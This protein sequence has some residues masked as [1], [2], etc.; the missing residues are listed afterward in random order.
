MTETQITRKNGA[1]IAFSVLVIITIGSAIL[2]SAF[3]NNFGSIDVQSIRF[4]DHNGVPIAAKL[5]RPT[6][7]SATNP[8]PGI[9]ALH[10]FNN[11]KDVMR[12]AAIE[13]AKAGFVVL[14]ID[15]EGD[16]DSGGNYTNDTS[17]IDAY[18]YLTSLSFVNSTDCGLVGHSL[19]SIRAQ[20]IALTFALSPTVPKAVIPMA[21]TPDEIATLPNDASP[22]YH[23]LMRVTD[24]WEEFGMN[25]STT[26]A[27]WYAL[28]QTTIQRITGNTTATWDTT[29][30]SFATGSARR[31]AFI[32]DSTHPQLT[33]DPRAITEVVAWMLQALMG[34]NEA[35]AMSAA[36]PELQTYMWAESLGLLA[37]FALLLSIMPLAVILMRTKPFEMCVQPRSTKVSWNRK[38]WWGWATMA[39]AIGGITY[40]YL[41]SFYTTLVGAG[42]PFGTDPN[43]IANPLFTPITGIG[44][45][46]GFMGWFLVNA[47]IG[48]FFVTIWY[49]L[50]KKSNK[51]AISPFDLGAAIIQVKK[52]TENTNRPEVEDSENATPAIELPSD[53][54]YKWSFLARTVVLAFILYAWMYLVTLWAGY[55]LNIE[56]NGFWTLMKPIPQ[57]RA[58]LFWVYFW[59]ILLFFLVS[60]G[61]YLFGEMKLKDEKSGAKTQF[62]WWI[63]YCYILLFGLIA[64]ILIQYVPMW[65][66]YGPILNGTYDAN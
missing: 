53:K 60:G 1:A 38:Q 35:D 12:P 7:V 45:A 48:A 23:N 13:L 19:G 2:S 5:Y 49:F 29:Y 65:L 8:A 47:G 55:S 46:T 57:Q 36:R 11:D 26:Q 25:S 39:T 22:A 56:L 58:S 41:T 28:G 32:A 42:Q 16:G 9:L 66:G 52:G 50:V 24:S 37:L 62:V 59:P 64:V 3:Q 21:F 20:I 44:V 14:V 30:G 40:V 34:Y 33:M 63:K 51:E 10:G 54:R 4:A 18:T 31:W 43:V 61:I 15:Q 17:Y 6:L 27:E